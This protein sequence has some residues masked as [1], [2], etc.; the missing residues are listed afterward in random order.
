MKAKALRRVLK[1]T[2]S[3]QQKKLLGD[4]EPAQTQEQTK[5]RSFDRF[6]RSALRKA[7][8]HMPTLDQWLATGNTAWSTLSSRTQYRFWEENSK[9]G[10]NMAD[11][12]E[13][14]AK[15]IV[16]EYPDY[17]LTEQEAAALIVGTAALWMMVDYICGPSNSTSVMP[18]LNE[19]SYALSNPMK[20]RPEA[21]AAL[22][23]QTVMDRFKLQEGR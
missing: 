15:H 11:A 19:G 20:V 4:G 14:G 6:V 16:R 13:A 3:D 2:T 22:V 10:D 18:T 17:K 12:V 1:K 7:V 9:G 5:T 21:V 23:G 8:P